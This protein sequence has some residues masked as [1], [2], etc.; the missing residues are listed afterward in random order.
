MADPSPPLV[1]GQIL[2]G[3][4][5]VR[6]TLGHGAMGLVFEA[7]HRLLD[8]RVAIKVLRPEL[9]ENDELRSRFEAEA[10]SAAAIGHP[11]IV[12]VTDMGRTADGALYFV[13]D[14]LMGETLGDRLHRKGRLDAATAVAVAVEV[15]SGLEAAHALG[16]VHRDLKPENIFLAVSPGGRE[17]AKILDFGV[18]K[19]LATVGRRASGTQVGMALGTP[20]YMAPEQARGA[21]DLDARVDLYAM[22][23]I[24]Y[25]MLSGRNPFTG[26]NALA[27]LTAMLT[28]DPPSLGQLCPDA[29][30]ALVALAQ[31]AMSRERDLRPRSATELRDRLLATGPGSVI[32]ASVAG[33]LPM[34][35]TGRVSGPIY[36]LT[37]L[38]GKIDE[39]TGLPTLGMGPPGI[40][41]RNRGG[42][43]GVGATQDTGQYHPP[44]PVA[45][46]PALDDSSDDRLELARR[47][48]VP[49]APPPPE[50][51]DLG[52]FIRRLA[53][54]SMVAVA[55]FTVTA[56]VI[57]AALYFGLPLLQ[58]RFPNTGIPVF[59][60]APA[61]D[62]VLV[63]VQ[64]IPQGSRIFL[65]GGPLISNPLR[66]P[67]DAHL[68][69]VMARADGYQPGSI[70]FR[71]DR[72]QTVHLRL[73]PAA[74]PTPTPRTLTK[75]PRR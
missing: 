69:T 64:V 1:A 15:L 59:K 70:E 67:R 74:T 31:S 10:R 24:L 65:D 4:Y 42:S 48:H 12:S 35:N 63:E 39:P 38:G 62:A 25:R 54:P 3:K 27:V 51:F 23:V 7:H 57:G 68:H 18:A 20:E 16:L 17:T 72:A 5:E 52:A 14:R 75:T 41:V 53:R 45:P 34:P 29:P 46:P 36:S 71:A 66:L 60:P 11:N 9:S 61:D 19:A 40:V 8:K 43:A 47:V 33:A 21:A 28:M 32:S 55:R 37:E 49:S 56:A 58:E 30:P 22:G 50:P 73:K 44:A 6:G 13:M 26:D 2:D